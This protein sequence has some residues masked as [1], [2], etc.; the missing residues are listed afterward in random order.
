MAHGC[1]C[2]IKL[3]RIFVEAG[4]KCAVGSGY[5]AGFHLRHG[6]G[7][8]KLGSGAGSA[9]FFSGAFTGSVAQKLRMVE[10]HAELELSVPSGGWL[11]LPWGAGRGYGWR[12]KLASEV[13]FDLFVETGAGEI[14]LNLERLQ[15]TNLI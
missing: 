4:T 3:K 11:S 6:A 10:E 2:P 7:G 5:S 14:D 15:V 9:V 1:C 8:I 12:I 13:P